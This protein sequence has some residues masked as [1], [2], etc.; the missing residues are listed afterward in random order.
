MK[1]VHDC[2]R[3]LSV[4]AAAM[5][6]PLARAALHRSAL[7]IGRQTVRDCCRLPFVAAMEMESLA[8]RSVLPPI[9]M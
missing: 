9:A 7:P 6:L 4:A 2:Y 8:A 5:E 1:T 3:S